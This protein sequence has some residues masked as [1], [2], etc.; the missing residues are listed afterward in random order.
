VSKVFS[1][2][3]YFSMQSGVVT[4]PAL[5]RSNRSTYKAEAANA[6]AL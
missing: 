3:L 2:R 4:V 5:L 1:N 6:D